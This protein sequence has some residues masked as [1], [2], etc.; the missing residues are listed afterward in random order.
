MLYQCAKCLSI[1]VALLLSIIVIPQSEAQV[2]DQRVR[3]THK[4]GIQNTGRVTEVNDSLFI[5]FDERTAQYRRFSYSSV[6]A[7]SVSQGTRTYAKT[8][9]IIGSILGAGVYLVSCI[10]LRCGFSLASFAG[11]ALTTAAGA[12]SGAATGFYFKGERWLAIPLRQQTSVKFQPI[13][14][15]GLAGHPVLGVRVHL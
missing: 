11:F 15:M 14:N 2:I 5:V 1:S 6:Q 12:G 10:E 8:G 4:S 7:L 3:V 9:L 13:L